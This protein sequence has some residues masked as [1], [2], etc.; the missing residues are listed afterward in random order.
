[1]AQF[2]SD[3]PAKKFHRYTKTS[4]NRS[5]KSKNGWLKSDLQRT[6]LFVKEGVLEDD[7]YG[8]LHPKERPRYV[9]FGEIA[10]VTKGNLAK[11]KIPV[12][13]TDK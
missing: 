1:M 12:Y 13:L 11:P 10:D 9:Y 8:I 2:S 4:K 6:T 3:L 7:C 5:A